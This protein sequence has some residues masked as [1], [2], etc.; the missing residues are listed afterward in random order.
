MLG[1]E[2]FRPLAISHFFFFFLS[3]PLVYI[4]SSLYLYAQT[5]CAP[6]V[7]V[8]VT[9]LGSEASVSVLVLCGLCRWDGQVGT[10]MSNAREDSEHS[11]RRK[12]YITLTPPS[13]IHYPSRYRL[14]RHNNPGS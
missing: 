10:L 8:G 11:A 2:A 13:S 6:A 9:F 4:P 7:K 12:L 5:L 14:C 3:S 1:K